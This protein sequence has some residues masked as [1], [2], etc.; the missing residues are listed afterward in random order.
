MFFFEKKITDVKVKSPNPES[1]KK[2]IKPQKKILMSPKK[3]NQ[4][5]NRIIK[6]P[7]KGQNPRK[8]NQ[9]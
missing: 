6:S 4:A 1:S 8:K 3:N 9:T 2:K 5:P 7:K